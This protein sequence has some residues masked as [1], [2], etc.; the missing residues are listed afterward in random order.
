MSSNSPG[1][2]ATSIRCKLMLLTCKFWVRRP[3]LAAS[4]AADPPDSDERNINR[5]RVETFKTSRPY[6]RANATTQIVT[7]FEVA[8][9]A[10]LGQNVSI[11]PEVVSPL[12][13][14]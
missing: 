14:R 2:A 10:S 5:R 7:H 8:N 13:M 11:S 6:A 9:D 3:A 1:P 4:Y 12:L